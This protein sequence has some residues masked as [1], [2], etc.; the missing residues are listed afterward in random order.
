VK[1]LDDMLVRYRERGLDQEQKKELRRARRFTDS[2]DEKDKV[3][4]GDG[5]GLCSDCV[6]MH[7]REFEHGH[8]TYA[9]CGAYVDGFPTRL[10]KVHIVTKCSEF[11]RK[12]LLSIENMW[13]IASMIDLKPGRVVTGFIDNNPV[14][15]PPTEELTVGDLCEI[16]EL[17]EDE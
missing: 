6:H 5:F 4:I 8:K 10:S 3:K 9:L 17:L 11:G 14:I 15:T 16:T 13:A 2:V 1:S 12:G 7:Y